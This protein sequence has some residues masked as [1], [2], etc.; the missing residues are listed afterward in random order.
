MGGESA[1]VRIRV[2]KYGKHQS[3]LWK[4]QSMEDISAKGKHV[5]AATRTHPNGTKNKLDCIVVS[6]NVARDLKAK[7]T[8]VKPVTMY[9]ED[10]PADWGTGGDPQNYTLSDH[11]VV[12]MQIK[13]NCQLR[14]KKFVMSEFTQE[15]EASYQCY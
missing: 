3:D 6:S 15:A 4:S 9:R 10:L 7:V 2:Q 12:I 14:I 13:R 11:S 5:F 8:L 1:A